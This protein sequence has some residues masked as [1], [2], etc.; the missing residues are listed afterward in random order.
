[1]KKRIIVLGLVALIVFG[2]AYAY[3]QGPGTGPAM[4]PEH[5]GMHGPMGHDQWASLTPEQKAKFQEFHRKFK[6]ENAKLIGAIVAKR[7]ELQSIW[8][9]PKA[10]PKAIFEKEKEFRD[11]QN[12]LK[13]KFVLLRLECR[14]LLTPEQI[15]NGG[16]FGGMGHRRMMCEDDEMGPPFEMER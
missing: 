11:L 15:K 8:T 1:M 7:L 5:K 6:E 9:D 2:V 16:H 14:K 12:Q 4:G 13:E 10:D 3:A